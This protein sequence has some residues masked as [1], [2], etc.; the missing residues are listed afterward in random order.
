[1]LFNQQLY[2]YYDHVILVEIEI[3]N[4]SWISLSDNMGQASL[5]LRATLPSEQIILFGMQ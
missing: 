1:M 5:M 4:L 3:F 2:F